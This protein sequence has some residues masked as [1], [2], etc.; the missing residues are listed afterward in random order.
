MAKQER[1]GLLFDE[2][3]DAA[4]I[5]C[6][7]IR[8]GGQ[9]LDKEGRSFGNG[10]FFHYKRLFKLYWPNEDEHKWEDLGLETILSNQ[11]STLM[12]CTGSAKTSTAAKF[13]LCFYSVWPKGTTIL[14][15][16]TDMRGL[17]M[18]VFGRLKEL[19]EGAKRRFEWFPGNVIDSKKVVA[20]DDLQEDEIR[21]LRDGI[22]C[23]PCLSSNGSFVGLGRYIGIHNARVLL[24]SDECFPAGT[25]VDTPSGQKPIESINAG[26]LV[27]SASGPAR[28]EATRN[29]LTQTLCRLHLS[30]GKHIDCTPNHPFL[31]S[32][33]WQKAI[34]ISPDQRLIS[35]DETMQILQNGASK[36]REK[37]LLASVPDGD[38]EKELRLVQEVIHPI[39]TE[40]DFL[41]SVL[42]REMENVSTG[43]C[44]ANDS[45]KRFGCDWESNL[46]WHPQ[47]QKGNGPEK[48][49]DSATVSRNKVGKSAQKL[50]GSPGKRR[51]C[52]WGI[53]FTQNVPNR[54]LLRPQLQ[55]R[56][57]QRSHLIPT[58][59][60]GWF[61]ALLPSRFLMAASKTSSG[62]RRRNTPEAKAETKRLTKGVHSGIIRVASVEILKRGSNGRCS[63][64]EKNYRVCNLQVAGHP[65]YSV[66]GCVVHNCQLMQSSFLEAVPNL[67]NNPV[68]K[69]IFLG[70]PLAQ[71]DPLDK[72]SEPKE[73]WSSVGIPTKTTTWKTKYMDGLCLC[74]PGLDSPN[75]SGPEDKPDRYGYMVGRQK[76]RMVR[77]SYGEGSQQYCSQIL[78]VRVEGLTARKVLTREICNKFDC[79]RLPVW[80]GDGTTKIYSIDAA[81]GSIGGDL[82]IGGWIEFGLDINRKQVLCIQ[83]QKIIPVSALSPI[84]PDDQIALFAIQECE[85]LGIDEKNIFFDGRTMLMAAFARLKMPGV[86]PVDFGAMPTKRP[87]SLDMRIIDDVTGESR[88]KRCDEHYSKFVTELWLAV[89]YTAESGQLCGMTEDILNDAIPR[90]WKIVRGNKMEVESKADMRKRTGK[91]PDRM[92]QLVTAVEGA[93]RRGFMISKLAQAHSPSKKSLDWLAQEA[94]AYDAMQST[95][96]LR[97]S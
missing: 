86:N 5:E 22:T 4:Q 33:G 32:S 67:L 93:R 70:N 8:R 48:E 17:E 60:R 56:R 46:G 14:I 74:L 80:N 62:I 34:D 66:E 42:W 15:S 35:P 58:E 77:E 79:F 52:F 23:I 49:H 68:A 71:N 73:G 54:S 47:K 3:W 83:Q 61:S 53:W 6:H 41:F 40:S 51:G 9:W 94:E 63:G 43:R 21:N 20:T 55:R 82:C 72:V 10:N 25:M 97:L 95:K 96:E 26:D 37:V 81:Y 12:G 64:S 59:A 75:F 84:P 44:S 11:F 90:E 65:S 2:E 78:G 7:M 45:R 36:A 31:T 69:F 50:E 29:Q 87:V 92:D 16:S 89:R 76:E 88:L 24:V 85:T 19:I 28:V 91:S 38:M 57:L 13:A 39:G 1:Y 30:N 27:I 18:R